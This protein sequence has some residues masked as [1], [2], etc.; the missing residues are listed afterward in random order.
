MNTLE[1]TRTIKNIKHLEAVIFKCIELK[2]LYL[3]QS[4]TIMNY[5]EDEKINASINE[6]EN[7]LDLWVDQG[8]LLREMSD[9]KVRLV[10]INKI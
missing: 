9:Y 6:V 5:L 2:H 3:F 4:S 1:A 7:L 8:I 10:Q